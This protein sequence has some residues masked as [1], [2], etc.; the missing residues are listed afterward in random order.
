MFRNRFLALNFALAAIALGGCSASTTSGTPTPAA[1]ATA[2]PTPIP[3]PTGSA[4]NGVIAL[5]SPHDTLQDQRHRHVRPM[6]SASATLAW[7]RMGDGVRQLQHVHVRLLH[8]HR[9]RAHG[10][11]ER[12]RSNYRRLVTA[13]QARL[14]VPPRD[15]ALA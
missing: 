6:R 2:T 15:E 11:V 3:T 13:Q 12:N 14:V 4:L 10:L 8:R 1:T 9:K 7:S 5:S